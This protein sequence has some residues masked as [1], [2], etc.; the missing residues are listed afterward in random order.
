MSDNVPPPYSGGNL[1]SLL[2]LP[3]ERTPGRSCRGAPARLAI[4]ASGWRRI[5]GTWRVSPSIQPLAENVRV[6]RA[7]AAKRECVAPVRYCI[8]IGTG[9]AHATIPALV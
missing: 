4:H 3:G 9:L 7:L 6:R 8:A 1:L 5:R 2:P